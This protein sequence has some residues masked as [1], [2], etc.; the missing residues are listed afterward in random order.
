NVRQQTVR[1]FMA[2]FFRELLR[3]GQIDRAMTE[4]RFALR[5]EPDYWA[6]VLF[7]RLVNGRLWYDRRLAGAPGFDAWE[8]L[9]NGIR[10]ERC[11]PILGSGLLEPFVGSARE[12]ARRWAQRSRFPFG[13]SFHDQLPQVAQF[14]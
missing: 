11:V 8:G 2:V 5:D 13:A 10:K 7:T 12:L 1:R 14:L 4:A 9:L 3:D 6:P